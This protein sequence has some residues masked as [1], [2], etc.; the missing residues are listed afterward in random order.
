MICNF[1]ETDILFVSFGILER[2][3]AT[4]QQERRNERYMLCHFYLKQN[5]SNY[6]TVAARELA[7]TLVWPAEIAKTRAG[8]SQEG[9]YLVY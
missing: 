5:L 3:D 2:L 4:C 7:M 8:T 6:S 9:P 1:D